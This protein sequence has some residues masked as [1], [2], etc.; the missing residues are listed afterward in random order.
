MFTS[1][2]LMN[3]VNTYINTNKYGSTF[4][5]YWYT[6]GYH[7]CGPL[8][9]LLHPCPSAGAEFKIRKKYL[10]SV[11]GRKSTIGGNTKGL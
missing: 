5:V 8:R 9:D 1:H 4:R 10:E 3:F 11:E 6:F 2:R 7:T